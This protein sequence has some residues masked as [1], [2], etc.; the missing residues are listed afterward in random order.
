VTARLLDGR[1]F[2]SI[3]DVGCGEGSN[4]AFLRGRYAPAR[5]VGLDL[6]AE[7]VVLGESIGPRRIA[8]TL[9][10]AAGVWLVVRGG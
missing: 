2:A 3:L 1:P 5:A 10:I 7:A 6:S 4:L 8:R 9:V